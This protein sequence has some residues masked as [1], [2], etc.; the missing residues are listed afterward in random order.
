MLQ[1]AHNC[2]INFDEN[3]SYFAVYDGHGGREISQY[4]SLELPNYLKNTE[5]YK[6]GD[7]EKALID[8]F[9]GLDASLITQPVNEK[10]KELRGSDQSDDELDEE[11]NV[12]NLY[13]EATM[14]IEQ[15]IEKYASNNPK[16]S[17]PEKKE[18]KPIDSAGAC[19]SSSLPKKHSKDSQ[20]DIVSSSSNS[21]AEATS[22]SLEKKDSELKHE[23]NGKV[24][25]QN[26]ADS[27]KDVTSNDGVT[28]ENCTQVNGEVTKD[29][30]S[31]SSPENGVVSK[32]G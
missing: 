30:N 22:S 5:A 10:L 15:V 14:P 23:E 7:M 11:E 12:Q 17:S 18:E 26:S 27:T 31:S 2:I 9:L 19:C 24:A 1:D 21:V 25:V 6:A 8:A 3:T 29:T 4:C 20:N 32:K 16:H 28:K 13:E